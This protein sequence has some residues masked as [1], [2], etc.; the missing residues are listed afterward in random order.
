[1]E[2]LKKIKDLVEQISVDAYKATVKGNHSAAIRARK[3]AQ[4]V[5]ELIAP[6]RKDILDAIKSHDSKN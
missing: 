5:K 6:F 2:N 1:M 4:K 3:N